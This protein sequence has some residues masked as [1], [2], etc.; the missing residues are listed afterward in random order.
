MAVANSGL[1]ASAVERVRRVPAAATSAPSERAEAVVTSPSP[2]ADR[3]RQI[4]AQHYDAIW[5][6]V[7]R[8]GVDGAAVDDA[9]QEVF[10]VAARR[11]DAIQLGSEHSF[12]YGTALRVA[13]DHRRRQASRL[14][15]TGLSA[16]DEAHHPG[17]DP[18]A[19][20]DQHRARAL[21]DVVIAEMGDDVRD[22]FV[23]F[24]L[25][26]LEMKEIGAILAIPAGT[27]ASRL[28]RA[29]EEFSSIAKRLRTR[30]A[31]PPGK[32]RVKESR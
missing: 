23:L 30:I 7:R 22:C 17:D 16:I 2:A 13:A 28:R 27:V 24:E 11:I 18:G 3:T 10:L 6:L 5:R 21:L 32:D 26:G 9:T 31:I 19:A 20:L 12:L 29:R 1:V 14:E 15:V 8:L 4:V 25:E